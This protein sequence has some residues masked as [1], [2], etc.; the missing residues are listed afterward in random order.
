[1]LLCTLLIDFSDD[2]FLFF[3]LFFRYFK[4]APRWDKETC[5]L[6]LPKS[7]PIPDVHVKGDVKILKQLACFEA[8]KELHKIGALTDNLVPDIV[9]EEGTQ[10]LGNFANLYL[11][12]LSF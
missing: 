7:C 3:N 4:P 10:E 8:C 2:L 9:E 6:H 12:I 11:P 1:M 5:T